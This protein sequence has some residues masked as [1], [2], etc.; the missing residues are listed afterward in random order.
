M[1]E[2]LVSYPAGRTGSEDVSYQDAE[3]IRVRGGEMK[4]V[5]YILRSWTIKMIK[6]WGISVTWHGEDQNLRAWEVFEDV[7][8]SK[9]NSE[10]GELIWSLFFWDTASRKWV[11]STAF[12]G[13]MSNEE[14]RISSVHHFTFVPTSARHGHKPQPGEVPC[15][16]MKGQISMASPWKPVASLI[17]AHAY[18]VTGITEQLSV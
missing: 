14:C 8:Y 7:A 9:N 13:P 17:R 15:P 5:S 18:T 16:G 4:R 10:Q 6:L 1:C 12:K 3:N 2:N 11:I